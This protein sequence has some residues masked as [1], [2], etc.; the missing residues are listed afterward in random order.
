[1][2]HDGLAPTRED[3]FVV[4]GGNDSSSRDRAVSGGATIA[5][6]F[7]DLYND[8]TVH[9]RAYVRLDN[10]GARVTLSGVECGSGDTGAVEIRYSTWDSRQL[11]ISVKSVPRP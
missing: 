9:G 4:A 11:E 5:Q 2:F 8:D 10:T 3:V 1:M 7:V 6:N